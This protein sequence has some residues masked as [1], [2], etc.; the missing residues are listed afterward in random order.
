MSS[1]DTPPSAPPPDAHVTALHIF[2]T[3][4]QIALSGFGGTGFWARRMLIER[5]GWLTH[6]DYVANMSVAQLLPGPNVFNL[7]VIVGHRL[8]GVLGSIAALSGI[9][10]APFLI[11]IVAGMLYVRFGDM[12]LVQRAL[13][14][15][16]SVAVGLAI[17]NALRLS[18]VLPKHWQSW[19]FAGLAFL[20]IGVLRLPLIGVL[21]VL[22]P[23][24]MLLVWR[25]K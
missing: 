7:A 14:G 11:M 13:T 4:T 9:L 10:V 22:A 25:K 2:V 19:V 3:F 23:V 16:S 12:S 18:T 17:A 6:A 1:A 5:R 21:A 20:G 24:S 15:I 8:G